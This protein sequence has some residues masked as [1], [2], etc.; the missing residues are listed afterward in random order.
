[1]FG[2]VRTSICR[3]AGWGCLKMPKQRVEVGKN[4]VGE[5]VGVRKAQPRDSAARKRCVEI[6]MRIGRVMGQIE[7]PI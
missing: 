7:S 2:L 3:K 4:M 6:L 1:M 5:T